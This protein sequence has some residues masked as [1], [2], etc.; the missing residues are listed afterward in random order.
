MYHVSSEEAKNHLSDLIE[1][2]MRGE[3]VIITQDNTHIVQ[4]IP[5]VRKK[6]PRHAGTAKGTFIMRDDF[7]APLED[8]EEYTA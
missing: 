6:G 8:F 2:A 7:D 1:A 5:I 4:L 3:T